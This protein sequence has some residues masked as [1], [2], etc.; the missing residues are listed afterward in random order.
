VAT[1]QPIDRKSILS[2]VIVVFLG[3]VE[4]RKPDPT[5]ESAMTAAKPLA[6]Y[7]AMKSAL[8]ER[9]AASELHH[10]SGHDQLEKEI[11]SVRRR[12]HADQQAVNHYRHMSQPAFIA[13]SQVD[14]RRGRRCAL[15]NCRFSIVYSGSGRP[16][17]ACG[18]AAADVPACSA[19]GLR[20]QR[21]RF[22][23][24]FVRP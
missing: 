3:C 2:S 6:R 18:A 20:L 13:R 24:Q 22:T 16:Q 1:H 11:E 7:S 8:R 17:F 14:E 10:Q 5:G 21:I 12:F 15:L 4:I 9:L 23:T 19:N